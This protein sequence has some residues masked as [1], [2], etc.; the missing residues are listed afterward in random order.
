[1]NGVG[2]RDC[3]SRDRPVAVSTTPPSRVKATRSSA[4]A[5]KRI[6]RTPAAEAELTAPLKLAHRQ[7]ETAAALRRFIALVRRNAAA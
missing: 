3:S 4:S 1:M 6:Y 7:G 5:S 2:H